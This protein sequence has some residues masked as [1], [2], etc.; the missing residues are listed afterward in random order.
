VVLGTAGSGKTTLA[1]LRA[2]FLANPRLAGGGRTLLVTFNNLLVSYLKTLG[3]S[4]LGAVTV[5]TY[6]KFARGY[7][8]SRG[9]MRASAIADGSSRDELLAMA[10]EQTT[11]IH[12]T[13]A[14]LT[15][16]IGFFA[17]EIDWIQEQGISSLSDYL[18]TE[19][20]GRGNARLAR[21]DRPLVF[22]AFE[23]YRELR[24][25]KGYLYDWASIASAVCAELQRDDSPRWYRHIVIDE[26]QD[27]SPQMLRSLVAATDSA[28]SLTFF[29]DAAQ[30][31][32]GTSLSWKKAGLNV[33]KVWE[34]KENYRNSREI[35]RLAIAVSQMDYFKGVLDLVEPS[36]PAAAGPPPTLVLFADR[37]SQLR[38]VADQASAARGRSVAILYRSR[39]HD[40]T[41]R[42]LLPSATRLHKDLKLFAST[43]GMYYGTF[44]SAKGLEFDSV[45]IPFLDDLQSDKDD[46]ESLGEDDALTQAGKLLYV[47]ITRC[48]T[49]LVFTQTRDEPNLLPTQGGLYSILQR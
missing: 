9:R 32:Y 10:L 3:T 39:S 12:Q 36:M 42:N 27:F 40:R 37:Q 49:N 24:T 19:R 23:R 29:G 43:P 2:A 8:N 16:P 46:I 17:R 1:I 21:S 26:G 18:A 5:E 14:V 41:F 45:I 6:H 20:I 4:E 38:F 30:Q 11:R 48:R 47:G 13:A 44:H 34:F 35:A 22:E 33:Q 15:R 25:A 31:I 7:L 28:G